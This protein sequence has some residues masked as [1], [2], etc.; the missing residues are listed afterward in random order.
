MIMKCHLLAALGLTLALQPALAR[1]EVDGCKAATISG[2]SQANATGAFVGQGTIVV[3]GMAIAIDWVST[4]SS[5]EVNTDGTLAITSSHHITSASAANELDFTTS[6]VIA[7][8]P[9]EVPGVYTFSSHLA[10]QAGAGRV[11]SGYLD[12]LG[13]VDLNLGHVVLDS[14]QGYLCAKR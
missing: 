5:F 10:V 7:G 13:H 3:F 6:D 9:T 2:E 1:A 8:V 4:I 14:S 12:V 11:A